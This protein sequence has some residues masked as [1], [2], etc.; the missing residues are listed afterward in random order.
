MIYKTAEFQFPV[1]VGDRCVGDS[2][3][4]VPGDIVGTAFS[5]GGDFF[6]TAGH[7]AKT[8][9]GRDVIAIGNQLGS[10]GHWETCLILKHE[11]LA[12]LDLAVLKTTPFDAAKS[13]P[14]SVDEL[15]MNASVYAA[16][17]PYALNNPA[18][19]I[20][21]RAFSGSICSLTRCDLL[22]EKPPVYELSFACPRGL[23]GAPLLQGQTLV[24][25]VIGNHVTEMIIYSEEEYDKDSESLTIYE[26][27]ESLHLG[28][29][30]RSNAIVDIQ[31]DLLEC[32]IGTHLRKHNLTT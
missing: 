9:A 23:S 16:G 14:W 10:Q 20:T 28:I 12:D 11:V 21:T 32:T 1:M 17:F 2:T 5:I 22:P 8:F 19:S 15:T 18:A 13:F 31:S 24:G 27:T 7:V 6:I 25:V 3:R 29:A 30:V 26:K 4:F